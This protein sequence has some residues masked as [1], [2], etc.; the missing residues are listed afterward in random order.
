MRRAALLLALAL[1][2]GA[3]A[4]TWNLVGQAG[5]DP[6]GLATPNA[7]VAS[8]EEPSA[9]SVN[10]AA[11]G[12]NDGLT[13]QYFHERSDRV[14]S[15]DGVYLAAGP[16]FLTSEWL[17]P[18]AGPRYRRTSFGFALAGRAA[19][20]GL[21]RSD[22]SS[23]D[24]ALEARHGWDVGLTVRPARWLS[25]GLAA[26]DLDARRGGSGTPVR[27]H[28]GLATRQLDDALTAWGDW[29]ADDEGRGAFRS[30]A[31]AFGAAFESRLGLSLG[32]QLQLPT[33]RGLPGIRGRPVLLV[34]LGVNTRRLGASVAA[35]GTGR[36]GESSSVVGVRLS[37]TD[38]RGLELRP[39][40]VVLDLGAALAPADGLLSPAPPDPQ[41]ALLGRLRALRDDPEVGTLV[42]AI[43]R[44]GVGAAR[45]EELREAL[46]SVRAR[47]P[48]VAWLRGGGMAEYHV[49]TAA[50]RIEMAPLATLFLT[51]ISASGLFLKD[52]LAKVGVAFEVVAIGKY[53][54]AG[55]SYARSDMSPA[56]R[57]ATE[58]LLDDLYGRRVKAIAE[59]RKLPEERVRALIDEGLFDAA[60]AREAK[61][62]DGVAYLDEVERRLGASA[63]RARRWEPPHPRAAQRWGPRPAVALVRVSGLVAPGSSRGGVIGGPVAGAE[64]VAELVRQAAG[65]RALVLRIESPG[66]DAQASDAIARAVREL[67][68]RGTPV[69]ASLGDVAASGGYWIATAADA[70]VAEPGSLTGS[71]GVV[72][73]KPDLSGLLGKLEAHRVALRRGAR[74]DILSVQR[75]WTADERAAVERQ[76]GVVYRQ[77]VE[78]VAE[79][80]K[81]DRAQVEALAEGRLWTGQQA[82]DRKLVDRLGGLAEALALARERAGIAP[83]DEVEIRALEPPRPLLGGLL[84]RMVGAESA[85]LAALVARESPEL[86]L[87]AAL[88]EMGP[89]MA[90]PP[91]GVLPLAVPRPRE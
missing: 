75:P 23:R 4:Q 7:G 71:I 19:S 12:W 36:G 25:V 2:A 34:S 61:L 29:M 18:D 59:A 44:L 57:E 5:G 32:G 35:G 70:I 17:R 86:G 72:G 68:R 82:L 14:R 88:L 11:A 63:G 58:A 21:A 41:A 65:A 37:S 20:L 3:G 42:V 53:K 60:A 28:L 15:G 74:A 66:G 80:R 50:T 91:E 83:G 22:W 62:V 64:T 55:E 9:L 47:K 79:G 51:G 54:S 1:P 31:V 45:A 40:P 38:Y 77:F 56:D 78:R 85:S 48:V 67:R 26:L 76:L 84:G 87:A 89:V 49:A 69:V 6:T 16:L 52:A 81:L 39:R 24:A 73:M 30:R 10:P 90:L 8:A 43:D 13:L 27:Y 33:E 46:A